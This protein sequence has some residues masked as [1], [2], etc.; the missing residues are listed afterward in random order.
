M[1]ESMRK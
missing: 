1:N